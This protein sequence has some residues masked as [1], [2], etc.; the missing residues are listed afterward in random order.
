MKSE[1]RPR[2][3]FFF[4]SFG[5]RKNVFAEKPSCF[6]RFDVKFFVV[7]RNG[8]AFVFASAHTERTFKRNFVLKIVFFNE[9]TERS[10][11]AL[12]TAEMTACSDANFN[13]YHLF[14]TFSFVFNMKKFMNPSGNDV[15]I[16]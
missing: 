4:L 16:N 7:D 8:N 11:Y 9:M 10:D 3:Y 15:I 14:F 5:E 13:F 2:I 12:S 6:R 1:N